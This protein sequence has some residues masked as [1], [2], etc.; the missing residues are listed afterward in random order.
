MTA[1]VVGNVRVTEVGTDYDTH[2]I[3]LD[4]G[5]M[6]L[7]VLERQST[8]VHPPGRDASGRPHFARQY[9]IASSR[10]GERPGYNNVSLTIKWVLEDHQGSPVRGVASNYMC[11]QQVGD[12]VQVISPFGASFLMPNHPR[13]NIVTICTGT[14]LPARPCAR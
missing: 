1:T 4:F 7:P 6:P 14:G 9:S 5:K 2:H 11:D 10:N 12:A 13:S 8:G 3:V